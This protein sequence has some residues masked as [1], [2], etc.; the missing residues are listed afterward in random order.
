VLG[1]SDLLSARG[2]HT[3]K[4]MAAALAWRFNGT[5]GGSHG[6]ADLV[7]ALFLDAVLLS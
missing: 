6:G 4:K 1:H 3:A 7:G 2:L 5:N